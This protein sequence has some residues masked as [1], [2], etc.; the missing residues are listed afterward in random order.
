MAVFLG[1]YPPEVC[2]YSVAYPEISS[3]G[4]M[5]GIF[6]GGWG[7]GS[8]NSGEDRGLREQGSGG[9]SPLARV[10]TQFASE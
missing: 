5:P 9:V 6:F 10:S 2:I 7:G 3:G 4:V 8:T 1:V